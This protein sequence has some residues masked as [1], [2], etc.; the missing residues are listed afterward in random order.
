MSNSDILKIIKKRESRLNNYLMN[1]LDECNNSVMTDIRSWV[2]NSQ[3]QLEVARSEE[4]EDLK[5][6]LEFDGY[7]L[8]E[9]DAQ[10]LRDNPAVVRHYIKY[11]DIDEFEPLN[12]S[13]LDK[14]GPEYLIAQIGL[15]AYEILQEKLDT[16]EESFDLP[17]EVKQQLSAGEKQI[18]IMALYQ[19]LSQL[20]KKT[21][22]SKGV[23]LYCISIIFV[24]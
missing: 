4:L 12:K 10:L 2:L 21:Q 6:N 9:R 18:F 1:L 3:I 7:L 11:P 19:S 14:N 8:T 13:M 15:H 17:V 24:I 16:D 20:D 5:K 23:A 22:P